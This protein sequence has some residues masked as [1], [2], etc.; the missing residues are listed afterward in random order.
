MA[1]KYQDEAGLALHGIP[2][3]K[4]QS[5]TFVNETVKRSAGDAQ[6]Q[7]SRKRTSLRPR[8]S[9]TGRSAS[10][11]HAVEHARRMSGVMQ[12]TS[13]V[14]LV[15]CSEFDDI[16]SSPVHSGFFR[17]FARRE[18]CAEN[19]NFLIACRL[20]HGRRTSEKGNHGASSFAKMLKREVHEIIKKHCMHDAE[21]QICLSDTV[22][23]RLLGEVYGDDV[24][25][26]TTRSMK[27][28]GRLSLESFDSNGSESSPDKKKML[29]PF[30][31][32]FDAALK[33]VLAALR[34]DMFPRF[35]ISKEM[36]MLSSLLREDKPE[37]GIDDI[38]AKMGM[39]ELLP[40]G[41]GLSPGISMNQDI[42]L[43]NRRLTEELIRHAAKS[44]SADVALLVISGL[45]F[46][47]NFD[48]WG[49]KRRMASAFFMY[50]SFMLPDSPF[51]VAGSVEEKDRI[52]F[53]VAEPESSMF[54]S[55]VDKNMTQFSSLY[56]M[57][58]QSPEFTE[59]CRVAGT[60]TKVTEAQGKS[61][62]C[63]IL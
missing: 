31:D 5:K 56:M 57:F 10:T 63:S 42:A 30:P 25:A 55:F 49:T 22:L 48:G 61:S 13:T 60:A 26:A 6:F 23:K 9:L 17:A 62:M 21:E 3:R 32:V 29:L 7:S 52:G 20:W 28:T 37:A 38:I 50:E 35:T 40:S 2:E 8:P 16:V 19:L 24:I 47:K 39:L 34:L 27:S 14:R 59:A 46:E 51:E 41:A 36:E 58:S 43:Q 11:R 18:Y 54:S 44:H 15:D 4:R 45:S 53:Q 33:E 12:V 1:A